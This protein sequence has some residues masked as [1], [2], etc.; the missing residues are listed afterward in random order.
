MNDYP[1]DDPRLRSLEAQLAQ[2]APQA[3][4]A[5]QQQLLYHCAFAAGRQAAGKT[6]RRWQAAA[7][8]LAVLLCL[9]VPLAR[10]HATLA[11]RSAEPPAPAA[12]TPRQVPADRETWP[13]VERQPAAVALD[14][15]QTRPSIDASFASELAQFERSDLQLRSLSLGTLTREILKP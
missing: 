6:I 15:W 2:M 1:L 9:S 7:A 14:A 5:E 12:I 10:E 8:A 11:R 13:I 4:P 3:S